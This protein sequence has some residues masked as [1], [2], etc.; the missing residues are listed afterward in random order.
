LEHKKGDNVGIFAEN[1]SEWVI[2]QMGIFSQSM[3]TVSLYATLGDDAVEYITNHAELQTIIVSKSNLNGILK[4]LPKVKVGAEGGCLKHVIQFDPNDFYGNVDDT[5]DEKDVAAC[6]EHGIKLMAWSSVVAAGLQATDGAPN[7][8]SGEDWAFIM[9]TSGTTGKPK[10]AIL[11]HGNLIATLG[12][13]DARFQLG[14]SDRHISYL[15]LAHIFE[16][17]VEQA[18]FVNGG[19]VGFFQGNIKKLTL[20]QLALRPTLWCGVPRVFDKVYKVIMGGVEEGGCAK[21]MAF[22]RA[23]SVTTELVRVEGGARDEFWDEKVWKKICEEKLGLDQVRYIITGAAPCPPYLMEFL[24]VL[25]GCPV[26]QGYGMTETA[27]AA[28]IMNIKDVTTG[29]NG[30]PLPCNE[31]KLVDVD[32]MDYRSTDVPCPRGEVWIRGP[33]IFKGYFKNQKATDETLED[34]WLKTGDVGRWNPNG[35]L[36]IIDRK[37]NIFKL[38]QGEYIAAEKIELTYAKSGCVGQI[39]VYGN[40]F[41]SFILAIVVPNAMPVYNWLKDNGQWPSGDEAE[42]AD[43]KRY[44]GTQAFVDKFNT[45][46]QAN[47]EGVKAFIFAS[48][49]EQ[50][51][52]LKSFERVRDI[53]VESRI[54]IT[55]AGFTEANECITPTF[56]L[57][58]PY[59][60]KRYVQELMAM[61]EAKG[62]PNRAEEHWPGL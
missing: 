60:L 31:I 50:D 47:K 56:K 52:G 38:S 36:S 41:K 43:M 44:M 20:D 29:H 7:P 6:E 39:F 34:G 22:S 59:L 45:Q 46:C 9:Y 16:T 21:G 4:I 53:H 35:T 19:A 3:R 61:Y 58:R 23:L 55:G 17:V 1:R 40:S 57:R 48:L 62:E 42:T 12:S 18:V 51:G 49:K 10:G 37:K 24:K 13:T 2:S 25:I 15:P 11:T 30:A 27:A 8:P 14:P 26:I 33:N 28:T 5:V 54:D 32:E